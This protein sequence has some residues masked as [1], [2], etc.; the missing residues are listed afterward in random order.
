PRGH[1]WEEEMKADW[2][3]EGAARRAGGVDRAVEFSLRTWVDG[4]RR[5][6]EDIDPDVRAR[7]A[8]MQRRAYELWL[9]VADAEDEEELLVEDV[10]GRLGEIDAPTLVLVGEEEVPDIQAIADKLAPESPGARA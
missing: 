9:P 1:D 3:E 7:V 6:S 2:R 4:P 5:K 10:A 8:E